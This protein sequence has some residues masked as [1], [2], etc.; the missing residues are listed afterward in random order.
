METNFFSAFLMTLQ[1]LELK[2]K[3]YLGT[4]G[5]QRENISKPSL[6]ESRRIPSFASTSLLSVPV[7]VFVVGVSVFA[8]GVHQDG[9]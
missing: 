3:L 8:G 6:F 5:T 1:I 9:L 4:L 2:I 7:P